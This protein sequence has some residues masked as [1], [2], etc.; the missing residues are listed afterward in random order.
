MERRIGLGRDRKKIAL[1]EGDW[2]GRKIRLCTEAVLR[3]RSAEVK[4]GASRMNKSGYPRNLRR[5]S[6]SGPAAPHRRGPPPE[7]GPS[8]DAPCGRRTQ[9]GMAVA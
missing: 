3:T 1:I 6:P 8:H 5:S 9:E 2:N 4:S 7:G